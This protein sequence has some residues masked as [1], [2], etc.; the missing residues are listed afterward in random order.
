MQLSR[1]ARNKTSEKYT[2][3]TPTVFI[4]DLPPIENG[5]IA[6]HS[7]AW[8][9]ASVLA[10][11]VT[12]VLTRKYHRRI[13]LEPLRNLLGHKLIIYPDFSFLGLRSVSNF[14]RALFDACLFFIIW[15]ALKRR[16][17]RK[18]I[19]RVIAL[20]GNHWGFL[21]ILWLIK[22]SGQ[23]CVELYMVDDLPASAQMHGRKLEA[24]WTSQLESCI[25]PKLD[26]VYT[27]SKGYATRLQNQYHLKRCAF[28]PVPVRQVSIAGRE[29]PTAE[30]T[31]RIIA[32]S[33]SLN[34][35]YRE[36]LQELST[37]LKKL[38]LN[39][40]APTY[41]LRLFSA[42]RPTNIVDI[43]GD[44]NDLELVVG[45][46]NNE[47][48]DALSGS[49]ANFLPY[50]FNEALRTMVSTAFSCKIAEYLLAG[51]PI[52]VYGPDYASVPQHFMEHNIPLVETS[53]GNLT[54]LIDRVDMYPE[55][56]L[57]KKYQH[58][59]NQY[60]SPMALRRHLRFTPQQ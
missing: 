22:R 46:K 19:T 21:P 11:D 26:T 43:F 44:N 2:I 57:K 8:T 23:F 38:N 18:G 6:T 16:L 33:G 13:S 5:G 50:T 49:W 14:L 53:R 31:C 54:S 52:L 27:I 39:Q 60:H 15:P 48:L 42:R 51:R 17:N 37:I 30:R 7:I 25:L 24:W 35:L 59:L 4:S 36:P 41:R 47:L 3:L 1:K 45:L 56:F 28:L 29:R 32:F 40:K 55:S 9:M 34:D 58:M 10:D 20:C 12:F